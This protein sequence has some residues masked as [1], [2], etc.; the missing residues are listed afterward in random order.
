M[1]FLLNSSTVFE[2]TTVSHSGFLQLIINALQMRSVPL[3]FFSFSVWSSGM[4]GG[5][6]STQKQSLDYSCSSAGCSYC[7][8]R[9]AM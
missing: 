1:L 8:I 4:D 6:T 5:Y 3:F 7:F 2:N 9:K